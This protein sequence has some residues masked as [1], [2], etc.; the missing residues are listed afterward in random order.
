[1]GMETGDIFEIQTPKGKAY[2][3]FISSGSKELVRVLKGLFEETPGD[4]EL[5]ELANSEERFKVHY[6]IKSALRDKIVRKVG[7]SENKHLTVPLFMRAKKI[8]GTETKGWHIINTTSKKRVLKESLSDEELKLSP[9]GAW[10]DSLLIERI[11]QN[12]S[13]RDWK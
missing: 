3:Q 2:L 10:S 6:R 5:S 13:L 9:W 1:M 11:S 7:H 4:K 12:W 8:V